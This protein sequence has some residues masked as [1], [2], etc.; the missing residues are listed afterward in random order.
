M[1]S[2]VVSETVQHTE[3]K[4][5]IQVIT[6]VT[7]ETRNKEKKNLRS[8]SSFW[9][10]VAE[11]KEERKIRDDRQKYTTGKALISTIHH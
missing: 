4:H 7:Q 2:G 3:Q 8:Y 5:E 1:G 9:S 10:S 11:K 6:I